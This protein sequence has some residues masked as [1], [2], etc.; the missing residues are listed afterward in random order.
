MPAVA[1]HIVN[2]LKDY[3]NRA[4]QTGFV[5]GVSGGI[6]S[7]VVSKLC[8]M[9]GLRTVCVLMPIA[10]HKSELDR[11]VSHVNTLSNISESTGV[12]NIDRV[13]YD[14]TSV[15]GHMILALNNPDAIC[16]VRFSDSKYIGVNERISRECCNLANANLRSR[17]RMSTLYH[18][19]TKNKL[20]VVGTGNKVEDFGVGFFTKYGDGGVDLSP[21]ADLYKTEVYALAEILGI[22]SDIISAAPTDGL[23]DDGRNDESQLGATYAELERAMQYAEVNPS[24]TGQDFLLSN[25]YDTRGAEVLDLYR[26][27][28]AVNHHKMVPIPICSI[29]DNHRLLILDEE[30]NLLIDRLN[31]IKEQKNRIVR[32]QDYEAAARLR[33]EEKSV[34][35]QLSALGINP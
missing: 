21:I 5:V 30:T 32:S 24:H 35:S 20:L 33:D 13:H 27:R 26:S 16:T 31:S 1:N 12:F 28:H 10:Q 2:W 9:T 11:A 17:L 25:Q 15:Y 18:L 29:R 8:A 6:D 19:A 4:G 3:A 7:A 14:L 22:S 34:Y 23:W